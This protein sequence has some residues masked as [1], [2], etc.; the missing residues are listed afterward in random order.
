MKDIK[1]NTYFDICFKLSDSMSAYLMSLTG[2][3]VRCW[4]MPWEG[5]D[6][7]LSDSIRGASGV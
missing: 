7:M 4:W 3:L 2:E 6:P 1:T 5:G